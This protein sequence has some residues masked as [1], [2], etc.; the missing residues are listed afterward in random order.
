MNQEDFHDDFI[1]LLKEPARNKQT[2]FNEERNKVNK[3]MISTIHFI[4]RLESLFIEKKS[5]LK[6][7][8]LAESNLSM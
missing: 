7:S 8:C 3:T 5:E 6:P 2:L 4:L 1:D